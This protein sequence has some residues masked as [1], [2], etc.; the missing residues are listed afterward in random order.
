MKIFLLWFSLF[1]ETCLVFRFICD[2]WIEVQFATALTGEKFLLKVCSIRS[3]WE[4]LLDKRLQGRQVNK[5]ESRYQ[6]MINTIFL[7]GDSMGRIDEDLMDLILQLLRADICYTI[8]RLLPA[9]RK[10][11]YVGRQPESDLPLPSDNPFYEE[12]AIVR[13]EYYGGIRVTPYLTYD[14]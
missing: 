1:S 11:A 6:R 5:E 8:R 10:V 9:D 14:R 3:I 13:N 4:K 2:N 7:L 12:F